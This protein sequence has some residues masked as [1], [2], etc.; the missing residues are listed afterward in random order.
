[1]NWVVAY[2]Q[3][4]NVPKGAFQGRVT[5]YLNGLGTKFPWRETDYYLCGS[6][7]MV[8][9]VRRLLEEKGVSPESIHHEAH[10]TAKIQPKTAS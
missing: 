3:A 2:S 10:V 9:D 8:L 7:P 4:Q 1:M 6:A 5:D